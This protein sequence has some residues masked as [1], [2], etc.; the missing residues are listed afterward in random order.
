MHE[1]CGRQCVAAAVS[2]GHFGTGLQFADGV[3]DSLFDHIPGGDIVVPVGEVCP[4]FDQVGSV[5]VG[6]GKADSFGHVIVTMSALSA[7]ALLSAAGN[8][9]HFFG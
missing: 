6:S 5:R 9:S 4:E 2:V 8:I 3:F 1:V 7:A